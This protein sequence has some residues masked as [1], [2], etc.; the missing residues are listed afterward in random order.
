MSRY[1]AWFGQPGSFV[2]TLLLSALALVMAL[3]C[4]TPARWLCFA[5]MLCSSLADIILM[6]YR[7]IGAKLPIPAFYAGAIVFMAAHLLYAAATVVM[8]RTSGAGVFNPGFFAAP[9]LA[10]AVAA[11]IIP[12]ALRRPFANP[13]LLTVCIIY[14][15]IITCM[16]TGVF[17][18][19][20]AAGGWHILAAA[21]ALSFF[22][23]DVL[24]GLEKLAGISRYS[25]GIWWFYPIGQF[26]LQLFL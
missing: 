11:W 19:A 16:L 9:V 10:A 26:L 23:S 22:I 17:A 7:G 4:H 20:W 3:I 5:A 25:G 21:G 1:F 8:L 14:L 13:L 12:M 18:R 6:N 15:C 24:I 2:L